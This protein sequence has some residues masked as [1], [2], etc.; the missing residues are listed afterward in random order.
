LAILEKALG[1]DHPDVANSLNNLAALYQ[2]QG[3]NA[4]AEPLYKQSVAILER[5]LGPDHPEIATNLNNLGALYKAQGRDADAELLYA[6][7]LMIQKK[8]AQSNQK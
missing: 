3:R 6:R 8:A 5:S 2:K 1:P 4:D 7:S